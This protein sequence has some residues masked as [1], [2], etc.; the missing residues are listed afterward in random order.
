MSTASTI[1]KA[2]EEIPC[3]LVGAQTK[4]AGAGEGAID[5]GRRRRAQGWLEEWRMCG[6]PIAAVKREVPRVCC[7]HAGKVAEAKKP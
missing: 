6:V 5:R 4:S 3:L 7:L 2:G 1:Q